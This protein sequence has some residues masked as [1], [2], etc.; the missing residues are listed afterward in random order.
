[1]LEILTWMLVDVCSERKTVVVYFC[2]TALSCVNVALSVRV[3]VILLVVDRCC[4]NARNMP[5]SVRAALKTIIMSE[6]QKT[7]DEAEKY[8]DD[9]DR[10]RRYQAE[11]W[12]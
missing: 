6:G 9:M 5:D 7:E 3:S 4:R 12:S 1:M 2:I 11:T 10:T 8:V